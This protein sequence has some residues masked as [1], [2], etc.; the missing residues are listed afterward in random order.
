ME[1]DF[2]G[3]PRLLRAL[4]VGVSRW[5]IGGFGIAPDR[6]ESRS[7]AAAANSADPDQGDRPQWEP[8]RPGRNRGRSAARHQTAP[9]RDP[10]LHAGR[11]VTT[12]ATTPPVFADAPPCEWNA[13]CRHQGH[14]RRETVSR[15]SDQLHVFA[16]ATGTISTSRPVLG[17]SFTRS[18]SRSD[19]PRRAG[20]GRLTPVASAR[21]YRAGSAKVT[22]SSPVSS[23]SRVQAPLRKRRTGPGERRHQR[24]QHGDA[25]VDGDAEGVVEAVV[26]RLHEAGVEQC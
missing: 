9:S 15:R 2:C 8:R 18:G 17:T 11:C 10:K 23:T 6:V 25:E 3:N 24:E 22:G 5:R 16:R 26:H 14:A 12:S 21:R 19:A 7:P 13:V 1:R 4:S 20:Y